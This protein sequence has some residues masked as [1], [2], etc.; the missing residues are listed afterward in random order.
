MLKNYLTIAFRNLVRHKVTTAL[1]VLGLAL[2]VA[3]CLLI[4]QYVQDERSFDA[5]HAKA[6]RIHQMIYYISDDVRNGRGESHINL[7]QPGLAL[8]LVNSYP[9]IA[10]AVRIRPIE[11]VVNREG[12]SFSERLLFV[13]QG[14]F[15]MFSFPLLQGDAETVMQDRSSIILSERAAEKYFGEQDPM[16]L[17]M[18]VKLGNEFIDARVNGIAENPPANST[19]QFDFLLPYERLTA[20]TPSY[21]DDWDGLTVYTFVELEEGALPAGLEAKLPATV[22]L[23][24]GE[25][26]EAAGHD[27]NDVRYRLLPLTDIHLDTQ[28][29]G[30]ASAPP[31]GVPSSN[32][33]Y[34]YIMICL[35]IIVF[36]IACINF[37]IISIGHSFSRAR[38]VGMRKVLG[39]GRSNIMKQFVGE[40]L[41]LAFLALMLALPLVELS[42]PVFN[43]L[44][45][46]N[47]TSDFWLHPPNLL[48]L[49]GIW[50]LVGLL[51]GVYPS[52]LLA[53]FEPAWTLKNRVV[54]G[55][56]RS[57]GLGLLCVQFAATMTLAISAIVI[58]E[59]VG[60]MQQ[61][62]MDLQGEQVLI[63][64]NTGDAGLTSKNAHAVL[65]EVLAPSPLIELTAA[66]QT[67]GTAYYRGTYEPPGGDGVFN[68]EDDTWTTQFLVDYNYLGVY[69]HKLLAGRSFSPALNDVSTSII[70]NEAFVRALNLENPIGARVGAPSS[71]WFLGETAEIVGV[72]EDFHFESVSQPIGPAAFVLLDSAPTEGV[73]YISARFRTEDLDEVISLARQA[74]H[75]VYPDMPFEYSFFD[76]RFEALYRSEAQWR[77]ITGYASAFGLLIACLGVFG[78]SMLASMSRTKE[79][80]IRKV[81]GARLPGIVFLFYKEFLKPIAIAFLVSAPITYVMMSRWLQGFAYQ[82]DLGPDVFL[83]VGA[84][85]L[86]T[87]LLT[88]TYHAFRTAT[89]NPVKSLRYE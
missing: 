63:F 50:L 1:N 14:F 89:A 26:M 43:T 28:V 34:S 48:A 85:I 17:L 9:E 33:V 39:A 25:W 74:W 69:G 55:K 54:L 36:A 4:F 71:N 65:K 87:V 61:R 53:R 3:V 83:G 12:Q 6:D 29:V 31:L 7:T 42:L 24:H 35:G 41:L 22:S 86:L 80:G 72:V 68:N 37:L 76:E 49:S 8:D 32:I 19:I 5:F 84:G 15:S 77:Q 82:T 18:R 58:S 64:R 88:T 38:E 57:W 2:S 16:G 47:L 78:L 75:A 79:M 46:K 44:S 70:V 30:S 23:R 67:L 62:R 11:S 45:G 60:F 27:L 52:V 51:A 10:H 59:Q 40:A 73:E 56:R 13:E 21:S 20:L 66:G 81:F